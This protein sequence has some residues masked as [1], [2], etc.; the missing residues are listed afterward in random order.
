MT[1]HILKQA[2]LFSGIKALLS[3]QQNAQLW[4]KAKQISYR[5]YPSAPLQKYLG[6]VYIHQASFDP[7]DGDHIRAIF[8]PEGGLNC[9]TGLI[10]QAV[11][12]EIFVR[13]YQ[14][15]HE[16]RETVTLPVYDFHS[17]SAPKLE[18]AKHE[19]PKHKAEV[20]H[21]ITPQ[22]LKGGQVYQ[23]IVDKKPLPLRA[24]DDKASEEET[25]DEVLQ[26]P[27]KSNINPSINHNEINKNSFLDGSEDQT[28][29]F[30]SNGFTH[31]TIPQIEAVSNNP[32]SPKKD[33]TPPPIAN[34]LWQQI[35]HTTQKTNQAHPNPSIQQAPKAT[36]ALTPNFTPANT[37]PQGNQDFE[38]SIFDMR[39][40]DEVIHHK[41]GKCTIQQILKNKI[42]IQ[43]NTNNPVELNTDF[44]NIFQVIGLLPKRV[45]RLDL[46]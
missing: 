9:I 28:L 1:Y 42:I 24:K 16:Q 3:S 41:Y 39:L 10:E 8:I 29:E 27:A 21:P 26:P 46:K 40:G 13:I 43:A 19:I 32:F 2:P 35:Q 4:G 44:F 11:A 7:I 12:E 45:F 30:E 18:T 25:I 6:A 33:V 23:E 17:H 5:L 38:C 36:P 20:K 14:L 37:L 22:A 31:A 34:Q 15:S